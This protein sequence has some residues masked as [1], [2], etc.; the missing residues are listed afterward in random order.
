MN[1]RIKRHNIDMLCWCIIIICLIWAVLASSYTISSNLALLV[2]FFNNIPLH[3]KR[4]IY[5]I[6]ITLCIL[7]LIGYSVILGNS[8]NLICR[9]GLILF[10]VGNAYFIKI[11]GKQALKY[12][13]YISTSF[14]IFL[15]AIEVLLLF[16]WDPIFIDQLRH[17]ILDAQ[18]GDIYSLNGIFYHVQLKGSAILPFI[19]MLLCVTNLFSKKVRKMYLVIHLIGFICAGNFMYIMSVAL[20]HCLL[21]IR[22]LNTKRKLLNGILVGIIFITILAPIIVPFFQG[23]MEQKAETSNAIRIEQ[24][25]LLMVDMTENPVTVLF[26]KGLGN[27]LHVST[28]FRD[29]TD[30]IY[31]ELQT[32]YFLNQMGVLPFLAF[33]LFNLWMIYKY[34]KNPK[35]KIVYLCYVAYAISN[36]YILDTTQVVVIISLVAIE[37]MYR[38]SNYGKDNLYLSP[39]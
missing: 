9:F 1:I 21:Y 8:P 11:N 27:T 12:L 23:K 5:I 20:F 24:A 15:I 37:N 10:F 29:Y 25:A 2:L 34:I 36:P 28:S 30:N 31:F 16:V 14:C 4:V 7:I 32:I 18:I 33:V 3:K 19:Y 22:T 35:L 17:I 26:G 38:Y 13:M 6:K 39:V